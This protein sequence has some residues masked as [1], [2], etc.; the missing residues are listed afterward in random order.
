[1]Q[2]YRLCK[3]IVAVFREDGGRLKRVT[4][5]IGSVIEVSR[6]TPPSGLVG[7]KWGGTIVEVFS[8]DLKAHAE[9]N[10]NS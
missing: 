7:V 9:L 5:P 1:M 10:G 6:R 2:T 4:L 3:A 8:Q